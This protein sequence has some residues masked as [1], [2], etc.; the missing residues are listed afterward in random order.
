MI[1]KVGSIPLLCLEGVSHI[2]GASKD[3]AG[4]TSIALNLFPLPVPEASEVL[5]TSAYAMVLRDQVLDVTLGSFSFAKLNSTCRAANASSTYSG[6]W[7][8]ELL[9]LDDHSPVPPASPA[10]L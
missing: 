10:I 3:E 7:S 6:G 4:L 8:L 5:C 9:S 1:P 2:P